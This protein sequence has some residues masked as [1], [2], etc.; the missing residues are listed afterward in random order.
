MGAAYP[1]SYTVRA[2]ARPTGRVRLSADGLP[3]LET[4]AAPAHGGP[5]DAWSPGALLVAAAADCFSLSFRIGAAASRL[6]FRRLD[7]SAQG[8]ID[9]APGGAR[10]T[11]LRIRADLELDPGVRVAR[12]ER[13]LQ[14][15]ER[16]CLI[17]NSLRAPVE[18]ELRVR[19][20]PEPEAR[21]PESRGV[22]EPQSFEP[23]S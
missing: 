14:K 3:D 1:Q 18:L 10:L 5:G 17:T 7:C 8:T 11:A 9:S 6:G 19:P 13:L 15:A 20:A 4:D 12:A 22:D 21:E 16:N 23:N 2:R